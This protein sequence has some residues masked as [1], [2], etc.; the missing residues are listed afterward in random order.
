MHTGGGEG[1]GPTWTLAAPRAGGL[2]PAPDFMDAILGGLLNAQ[3]VWLG[4]RDPAALRRNL[5]ELL[6]ALA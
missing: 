1:S 6:A 3:A 2:A 5:I 4:T